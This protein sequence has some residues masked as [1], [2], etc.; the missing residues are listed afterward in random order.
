[1][2]RAL[3][4]VC[5]MFAGVALVAGA[6]AQSVATADLRGTVK[7]PNGAVVSNATV[8]ARDESRAFE[9]TTKTDAEGNYQFL[10]LPPG[11]YTL[12]VEAPGFGKLVAKDV[13]VTVG[14]KA[15][16][17]V[18]LKVDRKSTR[19]NSSHIQKSRMPSSA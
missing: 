9:R 5:V 11:H 17:S 6:M 2:N 4:I 13:G 18:T 14:Q 1:M 19:L 3:K 12:T 10:L 15:E 16:F 7:D 8:T